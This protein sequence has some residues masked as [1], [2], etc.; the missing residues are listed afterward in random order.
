MACC[1]LKIKSG[2]GLKWLG[3]CSHYLRSWKLEI[4]AFSVLKWQSLC[5]L[6]LLSRLERFDRVGDVIIWKIV[7]KWRD[8]ESLK[9]LYGA[10]FFVPKINRNVVWPLKFSLW[11][12]SY[13]RM[14]LKKRFR[15]SFS[16]EFRF[17]QFKK[18]HSYSCK[19]SM[20]STDYL[21]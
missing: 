12:K 5:A 18:V 14:R 21:I 4:C 17:I 20:R 3:E 6:C 15:I 2:A 13:A 1:I 10:V 16:L 7:K 11:G 9:K 8:R 19:Y